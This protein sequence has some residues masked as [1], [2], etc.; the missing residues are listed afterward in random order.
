MNKMILPAVFATSLI[1]TAAYADE[2]FMS[3]FSNTGQSAI[4]GVTSSVTTAPSNGAINPKVFEYAPSGQVSTGLREEVLNVF[5][6]AG[7]D[8]GKLTPDTEQKLRA[9]FSK[10][11]IAK[12]I[13]KRLEPKGFKVNSLA[14]ATALWVKVS[15]EIMNGGIEIS[16]AQ[17]AALVKQFQVAYS[18]SPNV[19][20]LSD[21]EKQR[22]SE[23]LMWMAAFQQFDFEQAKAGTKGWTMEAVK[24]YISK[25]LVNFKLNPD[26]L[27]IGDKG[28]QKKGN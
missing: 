7:R 27:Q 6:K 8:Q 19:A 25:L 11:D 20:K 15:F 4:S 3:L 12:E 26:L 17:S 14:T 24:A 2:G 10:L 28:L 16:D 22:T 21:T 23:M 5:L 9:E 1:L 18:K 13:G